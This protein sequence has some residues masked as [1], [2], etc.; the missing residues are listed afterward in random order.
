MNPKARLL[1]LGMVVAW[2]VVGIATAHPASAAA[3]L[4]RHKY[5]SKLTLAQ[6]LQRMSETGR[7]LQTFSASLA[8]TKVT[9][10]VNDRLTE[11]GTLYFR[12]GRH[13]EVR[14]DF[15]QP[16]KK[17]VLFRKDKGEMYLPKI[18]QIQVYTLRHHQGLVQQFLLLGFG[19]NAQE[20]TRAYDIRFVKEE[21]M[22]GNQTAL[23]ELF[24]R[25]R[26]V[27]AQLSKIDL[28]INEESWLPVQQQF[29]EPSGDYMIASYTDV[30]VNRGIPPSE[31]RLRVKGAKRVNMG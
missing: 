30:R 3:V 6:I 26:E 13:P 16:D 5:S 8:Y 21:K 27:A 2:L 25:N 4:G 29:F 23:L 7:H 22:G 31:F 1:R 17:T 18:N 11:T 9:V 12:N 24:P 28:W 19:S 10:L 15:N 20:L 14:I